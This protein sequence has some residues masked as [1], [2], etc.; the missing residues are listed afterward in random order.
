MVSVEV[1][2][3]DDCV[4][5]DARAAH[6]LMLLEWCEPH[7]GI[8]H[9]HVEQVNRQKAEDVLDETINVEGSGNAEWSRRTKSNT[10]LNPTRGRMAFMVVR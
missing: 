4:E 6:L 2:A 10:S 5:G 8:E 7:A 1:P 3:G 9:E